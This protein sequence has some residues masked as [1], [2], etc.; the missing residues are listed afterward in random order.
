MPPYVYVGA[1]NNDSL[2]I[3]D[4]ANPAAPTFAGNIM[5]AGA[6]NFMN[7]PKS[8]YVEGDYAYVAADMAHSLV[9]D[10]I[11]G[12]DMS[13]S[14]LSRLGPVTFVDEQL[15]QLLEAV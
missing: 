8:L 9:V 11:F 5:G 10:T 13:F 12:N 2:T 4:A 15:L 1:V 14:T 3:I 7:A 6:P